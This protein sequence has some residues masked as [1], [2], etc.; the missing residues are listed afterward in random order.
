MDLVILPSGQFDET[1]SIDN[2]SIATKRVCL[3]TALADADDANL[4]Q[5]GEIKP[6]GNQAMK[7]IHAVIFNN[8]NQTI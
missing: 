4:R 1:A 2:G 8:L 7:D 3:T 5:S 6:W